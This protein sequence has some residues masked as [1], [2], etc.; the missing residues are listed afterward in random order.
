MSVVDG[1]EAARRES[2]EAELRKMGYILFKVAYGFPG[3]ASDWVSDSYYGI[4]DEGRGEVV[5]L[6]D[7]DEV[8]NWVSDH[9]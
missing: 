2:L 3:E 8:E 7:L 4:P 6:R 9:R 5:I 1:E